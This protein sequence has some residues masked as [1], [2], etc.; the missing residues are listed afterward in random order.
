MQSKS[1]TDG[2]LLV[3]LAASVSAL[4]MLFGYDI[5]VISGAIL[6]IKKDFFLSPDMG[7][8]VVSSVLLGSLAGANRESIHGHYESISQEL[9]NTEQHP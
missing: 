6:F 5:G 3:Y 8:I 4:G 2:K 1:E 7:E 9:Q